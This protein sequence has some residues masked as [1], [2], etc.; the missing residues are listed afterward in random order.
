[1]G[2]TK[3]GWDVEHRI[4]GGRRAGATRPDP[5]QRHLVSAVQDQRMGSTDFVPEAQVRGPST[6]WFN[7]TG[8]FD[9]WYRRLHPMRHSVHRRLQRI[10]SVFSQPRREREIGTIRD[11][12]QGRHG[13]LQAIGNPRAR[14]ALVESNLRRQRDED[15]LNQFNRRI[16]QRFEEAMERETNDLADELQRLSIEDDRRLRFGMRHLYLED[17]EEV[18]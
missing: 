1:M 3:S 17:A 5:P 16:R 15:P 12:I 14:E 9:R 2:V 6:M 8:E 10:E 13:I 4:T 7:T 11:L 18:D